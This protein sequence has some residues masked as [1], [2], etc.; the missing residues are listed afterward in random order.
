MLCVRAS[1]SCTQT[2]SASVL[3]Y[4]PRS[5]NIERL[6]LALHLP[7]LARYLAVNCFSILSIWWRAHRVIVV[8][9]HNLAMEDGPDTNGS[10][11][12]PSEVSLSQLGHYRAFVRDA[13]TN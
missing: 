2:P 5:V 6:S 13:D 9:R 10:A 3:G 4:P 7:L 1:S 8:A 12:P 11:R